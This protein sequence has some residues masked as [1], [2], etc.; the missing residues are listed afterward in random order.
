LEAN[1]DPGISVFVD[2]VLQMGQSWATSSII[3]DGL[4]VFGDVISDTG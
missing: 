2:S 4:H 3:E 1:G